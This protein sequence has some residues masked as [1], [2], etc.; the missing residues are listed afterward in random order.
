MPELD[1]MVSLCLSPL[2][3][4]SPV[5]GN[6]K[7]ETEYLA[8]QDEIGKITSGSA[9]DWQGLVDN[10]FH[11]LTQ[12]TKDLNIAGYLCLGLFKSQ[13]YEGLCYGLA[14]YSGIFTDFDYYD[15]NF[16]Q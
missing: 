4:E 2:S 5:G 7:Y 15:R 8:A 12:K 14:I 6:A 16:S 10:C 9:A 1:E 11:L 3:E 13:G